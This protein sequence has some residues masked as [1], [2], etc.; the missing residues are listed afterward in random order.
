M[1][2]R[3]IQIIFLCIILV[4]IMQG[5]SFAQGSSIAKAT[6]SIKTPEALVG[7]F[8]RDFRYELKLTNIC[9]TPEETCAL[10]KG[11]CDDFAS[12]AQVV[13]KNMGIKSDV[14]IIKFKGLN[15]LHAVCI[16]KNAAG[17]VSFIS[18]QKLYQTAEPDVRQA[19]KKYYPDLETIIYTDKD[20]R[21]TRFVKAQ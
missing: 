14:V 7:W 16:W 10:K 20:M 3:A 13:L 1:R 17:N 12:L 5:T 8:T 9:Q 4:L 11:D 19:I 18:N 6:F 2:Q 15:V 21:Y